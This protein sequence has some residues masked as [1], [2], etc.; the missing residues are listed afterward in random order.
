L[1]G[2]GGGHSTDE[3]LH[4]SLTRM[5]TTNVASTLEKEYRSFKKMIASYATKKGSSDPDEIV[6]MTFSKLLARDSVY[7]GTSGLRSLALVIAHA[8]VMDEHRRNSARKT[9]PCDPENFSFAFNGKL[10]CEDV[11]AFENDDYRANVEALR[12][13]FEVLDDRSREIVSLRYAWELSSKEI[14]AKL[15]MS[16]AAVRVALH[17]ATKR[18]RDEIVLVA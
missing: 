7:G 6:S 11:Y 17:R 5:T 13:A 12:K 2:S 9:E 1:L 16:D 15:Q 18:L 8:A 14:S 3:H 10:S 4:S